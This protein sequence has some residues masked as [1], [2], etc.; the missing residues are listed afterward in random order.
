MPLNT[1]SFP[2]M[3]MQSTGLCVCV[4]VSVCMNG[5]KDVDEAMLSDE[6]DYTNHFH[7]ES[8]DLVVRGGWRVPVC[9]LHAD[10]QQES[11]V[12]LHPAVI[13]H[14]QMNWTSCWRQSVC[15]RPLEYNK[16]RC[17]TLNLPQISCTECLLDCELLMF[18]G[19]SIPLCFIHLIPL[20]YSSALLQHYAICRT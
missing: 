7:S 3:G 15:S 14:K 6:F 13:P 8:S 16:T 20:P 19:L 12:S 1:K 11:I 9:P 2:G 5:A 10:S 18:P 17:E 4:C